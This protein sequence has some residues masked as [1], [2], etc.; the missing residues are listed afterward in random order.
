MKEFMSL[1]NNTPLNST[2][3]AK[4]KTVEPHHRN[5][6][7]G[8]SA[9]LCLADLQHFMIVSK[10]YVEQILNQNMAFQIPGHV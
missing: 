8:P 6:N 10:N 4:L 2:L 7:Q 1:N 3:K 9:N 5:S